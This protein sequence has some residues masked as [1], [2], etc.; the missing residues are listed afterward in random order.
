MNEND[1]II[2]TL[3][4]YFNKEI[5]FIHHN[6]VLGEIDYG[7]AYHS[8]MHIYNTLVILPECKQTQKTITQCLKIINEFHKYKN[9]LTSEEEKLRNKFAIKMNELIVCD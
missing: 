5:T 4:D 3:I 9:D 7:F 2:Q 8:I 6:F 1:S